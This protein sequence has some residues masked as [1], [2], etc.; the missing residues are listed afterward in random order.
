MQLPAVADATPWVREHDEN[1]NKAFYPQMIR[2]AKEIGIDPRTQR[3]YL[4]IAEEAR[5][6]VYEMP[7]PAPWKKLKPTRHAV[8]TQVRIPDAYF[9]PVTQH[10]TSEHPALP[11]YRQLFADKREDQ[12]EAVKKQQGLRKL[13]GKEKTKVADKKRAKR[14]LRIKGL[15]VLRLQRVWRGK[16]ARYEVERIHRQRELAAARLQAGF[17][18]LMGRRK[19]YQGRRVWAALVFQ[20]AWRGRAY[21]LGGW[22][23]MKAITLLQRAV[24]RHRKRRLNYDAELEN[25]FKEESAAVRLVQTAIRRRARAQRAKRD[26]ELLAVVDATRDDVCFFEARRIST[27]R[28]H[29]L[30]VFTGDA[31]I[32]R[33]KE[34]VD[35]LFHTKNEVPF[36]VRCS[37]N[38]RTGDKLYMVL[39]YHVAD[40]RRLQYGLSKGGAFRGMA[41]YADVVRVFAAEVLLCLHGLADLELRYGALTTTRLRITDAG[42]VAVSDSGVEL[43]DPDDARGPDGW[44]AWCFGCALLELLTGI[45]IPDSAD[46]FLRKQLVTQA[47]MLMDREAANLVKACVLPG[48][49]A[50]GLLCADVMAHPYFSHHEIRFAK[51]ELWTRR[52]FGLSGPTQLSGPLVIQRQSLSFGARQLEMRLAE[53]TMISSQV[54]AA[55]ADSN[56]QAARRAAEGIR[57]QRAELEALRTVATKLRGAGRIKEYREVRRQAH[58]RDRALA[59][60]EKQFEP[61]YG[62]TVDELC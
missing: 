47:G 33:G 45:S 37:V 18:G 58:Q 29:G 5:D 13:T 43:R 6:A 25:W 10:I 49:T 30:R 50:Q 52:P 42:H 26:Y 57:K 48:P 23:E 7:L 4:W 21:R 54:T 56:E 61:T 8:R 11:Y 31:A 9:N 38:F 15:A 62:W 44:V 22:K 3:D 34:R 35:V 1:A 40:C 28:V 59:G 27:G 24:R 2:I 20:K 17:R 19:L 39:D 51:N 46:D 36:L 16:Q 55:A 32:R 53:L 14:Q 12:V 60:M 41:D